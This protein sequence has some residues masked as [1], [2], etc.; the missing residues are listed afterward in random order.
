MNSIQKY[1]DVFVTGFNSPLYIGE[2]SCYKDLNAV[3]PNRPQ[4]TFDIF[5][6]IA[7]YF[8]STSGIV[9]DCFYGYEQ[10]WG[11]VEGNSSDGM[12]T[13]FSQAETNLFMA[14]MWEG[15]LPQPN[16]GNGMDTFEYMNN[17]DEAQT[18]K[19][20]K[21]VLTEIREEVIQPGETKTITVDTANGE[22]LVRPQQ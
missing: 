10:L 16:G 21:M 20:M 14:G 9:G 22:I 6:Q 7:D 1:E 5:R 11:N 8:R 12:G 4:E 17:D 3:F 19:I 18:Y 13:Y 15:V 2:W